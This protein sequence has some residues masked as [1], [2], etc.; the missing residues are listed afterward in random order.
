MNFDTRNYI[1][2]T[3]KRFTIYVQIR[4]LIKQEKIII[5]NKVATNDLS[6]MFMVQLYCISWY[7]NE[8]IHSIR[9][10]VGPALKQNNILFLCSLFMLPAQIHSKIFSKSHIWNW[11]FISSKGLKKTLWYYRVLWL[12]NPLS[13]SLCGWLSRGVSPP[14]CPCILRVVTQSVLSTSQQSNL[15]AG[16]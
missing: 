11:L 3:F 13:L 1:K 15:P 4:G 10:W 5:L 9:V 16:H 14:W 2:D 12:S 7:M 6:I 8:G